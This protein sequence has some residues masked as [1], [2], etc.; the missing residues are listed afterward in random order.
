[1]NGELET[2]VCSHDLSTHFADQERPGE[3]SA[4]ADPKKFRGACLGLNCNDCRRY[5]KAPPPK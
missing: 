3:H 5:K 2:C 4:G 1:M